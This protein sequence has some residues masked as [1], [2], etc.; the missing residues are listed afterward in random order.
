M[1]RR[2]L[3]ARVAAVGALVA[4]AVVV[5]FA[6][7]YASSVTASFVKASSWSSG[8]TG[9][10][11]IKNETSSPI[12]SWKVEFDLPSGTT[13]GAY[14][15]ALQT[16]ASGRY[17]FTNREYNGSVAP[18]ATV[19]FG[20]NAAGTAEPANCRVNGAACTGAPTVTTTTTTT[21]SPTSTTTSTTTT[22]TTST[23]TTGTTT[24]TTT[25][26]PTGLPK[27]VLV[28]Y[29]HASFA[30]GSGYIRMKDVSPDWDII[31]LSFAEPT[32]VTS[33]DLRF[34]Q[35][36]VAE[37][38]NVE[39]EAEFIA[40][41]REKQAQ[42][43][44]VLISIGGQNGQVQL[45]TAAARDAFVRSVGAIID[46]YGLDGL[47]VDFEGHSLSLNSGDTDFRNPTTPVIVN[48]ISALKALKARY[49]AKFVLTMAP[50]T[51]FVQLGY[52][53]Y[54]GG[55]GQ[56]PRA[57]A[58]LPV[59]HAMRDDLTLL[60]VQHYNSG[61]IMGL[62]NQYHFMGGS[63]FH[64]SMADM[65]LAGF[66]VRGDATKFFPGL[67]QDQVAIGLPAS[68][69]AG[70][71]FT[72]VGDTHKALDCLMKG[73]N[74]G[75]YKPKATYPNLRGLMTWSVNWDKHNGFEFSRS[76]RAYLPR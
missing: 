73:T 67:R 65:V 52:Q 24:T 55:S 26:P 30:N 72:S 44:K 64:V 14:W 37:C 66:P 8:Y 17:T 71:G 50:E 22:T 46:R 12:T 18:G 25:T 60:H 29:L 59:I 53:F 40:G 68:V 38:P 57:G 33:G 9:Q 6:P 62:D 7:A 10:F 35:C 61:P 76:H 74:C 32:S 21:T 54:G 27:R 42:G 39:P 51:F 75:P 5:G 23:T 16:N 36:P 58:Y 4:S 63:D 3:L 2:V 1:S 28:G 31:N 48:L 49:G 41:I 20:F 13:V 69:N 34:Q 56:D 19:T 43:K 11:S 45:T 15:D 70:N 47:D